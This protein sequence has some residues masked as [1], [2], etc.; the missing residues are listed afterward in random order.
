MAS[1]I[2][3]HE[4]WE[5]IF[6]GSVLVKS[7]PL[8]CL[9]ALPPSCFLEPSSFLRPSSCIPSVGPLTA[10]KLLGVSARSFL[11]LQAHLAW[12]GPC[13]FHPRDVSPSSDS[14][15]SPAWMM[16][17]ARAVATSGLTLQAAKGHSELPSRLFWVQK[18][19][20]GAVKFKKYLEKKKK[21]QKP[22]FYT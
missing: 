7:H 16:T 8:T 18:S 14:E 12:P 4:A 13:P 2:S 11:P 5:V 15:L 10:N 3:D 20:V 19:E 22:F 6:I 1:D 9:P 17:L 21:I